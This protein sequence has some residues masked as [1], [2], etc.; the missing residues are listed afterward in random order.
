MNL[1]QIGQYL[2]GHLLA[3]FVA[4]IVTSISKI[5]KKTAK[6]C[7][8]RKKMERSYVLHER[9]LNFEKNTIMIAFLLLNEHFEK[10]WLSLLLLS[11]SLA[12]VNKPNR[13][14][15]SYFT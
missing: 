6:N 5:S 11:G 1:I 4:K 2:A 9:C 15:C 8:F 7:P 13:K 14:V 10:G 3:I 12:K